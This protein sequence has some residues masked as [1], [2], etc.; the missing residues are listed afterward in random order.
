MFYIYEGSVDPPKEIYCVG[1]LVCRPAAVALVRYLAHFPLLSFAS[2]KICSFRS[3]LSY[4]LCLGFFRDSVFDRPRREGRKAKSRCRSDT[5]RRACSC[6]RPRVRHTVRNPD[7]RVH[8]RLESL[9]PATRWG[10][11]RLSREAN[12]RC[13]ELS[14]TTRGN[15]AATRM[16]PT[17]LKLKFRSNI[18]KSKNGNVAVLEI[19]R[20]RPAVSL[21]AHFLKRVRIQKYK[22]YHVSDPGR[23]PMINGRDLW[24]MKYRKGW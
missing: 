15:S 20:E 9:L 13:G 18:R 10:S 16:D 11:P 7:A 17:D 21:V 24:P 8:E 23:V 2:F 5:K 19:M 6:F 22:R 1:C 4:R 3:Y 12:H 14:G